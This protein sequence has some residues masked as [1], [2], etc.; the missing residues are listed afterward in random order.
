MRW[1]Q[2]RNGLTGVTPGLLIRISTIDADAQ[3]EFE[4][5]AQ[6][7]NDLIINVASLNRVYLLGASARVV[8]PADSATRSRPDFVV[9]V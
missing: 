1:L 3:T 9:M 5:Q 8:R 7:S 2:L 6:F 4:T